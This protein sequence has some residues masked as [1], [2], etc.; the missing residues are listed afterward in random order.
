MSYLDT[1]TAEEI[2]SSP[3][4]LVDI[5]SNCFYYPASAFDGQLVKY[6]PNEI[7]NFVY[8]DHSISQEGLLSNL[9]ESPFY[10]Y[11]TFASREV[12]KEELVPNGWQPELP[13]NFSLN[14]YSRI[15]RDVKTPFAKWFVFQRK[16]DFN[17]NHGPFRFSLLYIGGEGVATFQALFWSSNVAP[18]ALAII[19]SGFGFGGNW[20]DFRKVDGELYWVAMNNPA[21]IPCKIYFGGNGNGY[22][23]EFD[24]P[25]YV[26][27]RSINPYYSN[28]FG[29]VTVWTSETC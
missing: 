21:G 10:G 5:L 7:I 9:Q 17:S 25:G 11:S 4:P 3:L 1:L 24:W 14:D 28:S 29:E 15:K 2:E 20:T 12:R 26:F 6:A 8:C 23:N 22:S 18:K 19:Q 13:P 27:E 16:N